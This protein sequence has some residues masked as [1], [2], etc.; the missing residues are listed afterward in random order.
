MEGGITE[1]EDRALK[2][3][4]W[5]GR[6]MR[7]TLEGR[8]VHRNIPGALRG[9]HRQNLGMRC[10]ASYATMETSSLWYSQHPM[11]TNGLE[12]LWQ[13]SDTQSWYLAVTSDTQLST[14]PQAISSIWLYALPNQHSFCMTF[15]GSNFDELRWAVI[16]LPSIQFFMFM[17]YISNVTR[18]QLQ[19]E[20]ETKATALYN[21][22]CDLHWDRHL[23]YAHF[24]ILGLKAGGLNLW[25]LFTLGYETPVSTIMF[26]ISRTAWT[27]AGK[28]CFSQV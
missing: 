8:R 1:L 14:Q 2:S 4:G 9:S 18:M 11:N 15:L 20:Q 17:V 23:V 5:Q 21:E 13:I 12:S 26:F 7:M 10:K 24:F 22:D 28:L 27:K 16:R 6:F 3:E 19:R 25:Y